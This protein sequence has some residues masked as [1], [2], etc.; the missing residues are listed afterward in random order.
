[1]PPVSTPRTR[2]P[3]LVATIAVA[4]IAIWLFFDNRSLRQDLEERPAKIADCEAQKREAVDPWQNDTPRG[5]A[6][7]QARSAPAL[8]PV[9]IESWLE[10]SNRRTK[11][12]SAILGRADGETDDAYRARV[13]PLIDAALAVPR[14]RTAS[15]RHDA[16]QAAHVSADQSRQIDAA[17]SGSFDSAVD[18][19]NQAIGSG[20]PLSPSEL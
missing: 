17:M 11:E 13:K 4:G 7:V 12:I 20:L 15:M 9:H 18:Y 19:A 1:M 10:R 8:P 16:E 3:V 6:A 5:V 14:A 2:S